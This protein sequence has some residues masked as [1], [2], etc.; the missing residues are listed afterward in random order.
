MWAALV[1][2]S[3]GAPKRLGLRVGTLLRW[4]RILGALAQCTDQAALGRSG[5]AGERESIPTDAPLEFFSRS[6]DSNGNT[7]S[8]I[9]FA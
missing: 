5:V 6:R 4:G 8:K 1:A 3:T 2:D 7:K 9:Q